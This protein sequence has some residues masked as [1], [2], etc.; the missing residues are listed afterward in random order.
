[1]ENRGCF[2][3]IQ[4]SLPALQDWRTA[5]LPDR[6]GGQPTCATG[7]ED[8]LPADVVGPAGGLEGQAVGLISVLVGTDGDYGL[9]AALCAGC[10][11]SCRT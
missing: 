3:L 9:P 5:Y 11:V 8:S 2:S 1:M 4:D 6:T 10:L 7:L